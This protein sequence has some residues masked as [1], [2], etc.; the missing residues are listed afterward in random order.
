MA[1]KSLVVSKWPHYDISTVVV[2]IQAMCQSEP[3]LPSVLL[4]PGLLLQQQYQKPTLWQWDHKTSI[5][6]MWWL[7]LIATL[8]DSRILWEVDL[9]PHRWEVTLFT[10]IG[11]K[12]TILTV[13]G[14]ARDPGLYKIGRAS[15]VLG[16]T[17]FS[18]LLDQ[19][20]WVQLLQAHTPLAS[21]PP[22]AKN[23]KSSLRL[24]FQGG[25]SQHQIK[26][27]KWYL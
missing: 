2:C 8:T 26:I 24:L 13:G 11:I 7:I 22:Q 1:A 19:K 20:Q 21:L 12:G 25:L 15:R 10:L 27:L 3:I 4:L 18:L 9:C 16:S 17:H 5:L 23:Q 6:P 14:L